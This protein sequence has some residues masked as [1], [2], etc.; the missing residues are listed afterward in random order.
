MS[1]IKLREFPANMKAY[2]LRVSSR[3]TWGCEYVYEDGAVGIYRL[4]KRHEKQKHDADIAHLNETVNN[5]QTKVD[6]LLSFV[7]SECGD[8]PDARELISLVK[9]QP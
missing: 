8:D 4:G 5:L 3:D 9:D 2:W 7:E 6:A 1:K